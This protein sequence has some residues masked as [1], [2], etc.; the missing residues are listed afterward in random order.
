[1]V[2]MFDVLKRFKVTDTSLVK[3]VRKSLS[4]T[5]NNSELYDT[6]YA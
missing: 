3:L 4:C 5:L 2:M 1:M 6:K